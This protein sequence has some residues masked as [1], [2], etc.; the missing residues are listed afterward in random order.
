MAH[1]EQ[2]TISL[3]M[4][5]RR[6]GAGLARA[7]RSAL[8]QVDEV[9]LVDTGPNDDDAEAWSGRASIG[10]DIQGECEA[11]GVRFKNVSFVGA[12]FLFDG[13]RYTADFAEAR[14]F[15]HNLVSC[16]WELFLDADDELVAG[17][18]AEQLKEMVVN[19]QRGHL[20][21]AA[22]ALSYDY[23]A[24]L[25][26][27]RIRLWKRRHGWCWYGA[28]H[29]ERRPLAPGRH[30][31]ARVPDTFWK[32]VHHGNA[33]A[34]KAR[35][36]ALL[37]H[38]IRYNVPFT[39]QMALALVACRLDAKQARRA[40][41]SEIA[42]AAMEVADRNQLSLWHSLRAQAYRDL[43]EE[44]RALAE[45]GA[46]VALVPR[47]MA[48]WA[49]LGLEWAR[50]DEHMGAHVA[51]AVA[52]GVQ[53][54]QPWQ[55]L[56]PKAWLENEA[57]QEAQAYLARVEAEETRAAQVF[58][59]RGKD[60]G[61]R[62]M[63]RLDF[64]VPSPVAGWGPDG[65]KVVGGSELAVLEVVPRLQQLGLDVHVWASGLNIVTDV[66]HDLDSFDPSEPRGA[67]VVWRDPRRIAGCVGFGHP[68]WLW[69]HDIPEAFGAEGLHLADKV[70]ALSEH[71]ARRFVGIGV[72]ESRIVQ[73]QN[74]LNHSEVERVLSELTFGAIRQDPHRAVYCSSANRGLLLLLRMWPAVRRAVP[75]A[76]LEVCY[77]LDLFKHK[78]TPRRLRDLPRRVLESCAARESQGVTFRGAVPHDELLQL[79]RTSGVWAYPCV[80]EEIFC[81][82]AV[83]AQALGCWP[84]TTDSGAL[85][86]TVKVATL[87]LQELQRDCRLSDEERALGEVWRVGGHNVCEEY[88]RMLVDVMLNPPSDSDRANLSSLVLSIYDWANVATH[89]ASALE[90]EK[91][92]GSLRQGFART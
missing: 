40:V 92:H 84:V 79:L 50:R 33:A 58:G 22:M 18:D 16:D 56:Y 29:E 61:P 6:A 38:C 59:R 39:P 42:V 78:D 69:A 73:S 19:A 71:H 60:N 31:V 24:A 44:D 20:G 76:R 30:S 46:A 35:N 3:V 89:F 90:M 57:K 65:G 17:P 2:P 88:I 5:H 70:F 9:V 74:G 77:G 81:I 28:L 13:R 26:Q 12:E 7:V 36:A 25:Q 48:C 68:V 32:V 4:I 21:M 63:K 75:D 47:N 82:A 55:Y 37:E 51:L 66:W 49:E 85:A 67:V 54:R 41:E 11:R 43:G 52:Y 27:D 80:F 23:D 62:D 10:R 64:V 91:E 86:E 34:S 15:A 8:E 1:S 87:P 72:E 83:E 53:Q 45:L 14:N